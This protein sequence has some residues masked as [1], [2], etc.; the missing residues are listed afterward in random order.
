MSSLADKTKRQFMCRV[1]IWLAGDRQL[2]KG[3]NVRGRPG[4]RISQRCKIA[5]KETLKDMNNVIMQN[6]H[7]PI[8]EYCDE[9]LGV[10]DPAVVP[11]SAFSASSSYDVVSVGP[12]SA[13]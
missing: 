5:R 12:E 11:D 6:L 8:S 4:K 9:S 1:H 13:R 3:R 10:E 7:F 2:R